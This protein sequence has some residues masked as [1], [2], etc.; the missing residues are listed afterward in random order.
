MAVLL[1]VAAG[2]AN[3]QTYETDW[4]LFS[5]GIKMALKGS[6]PG[7]QQSA[8]LLLIKYGEQLDIGDAVSDLI[9]YYHRQKDQTAKRM[10]LLALYRIDRDEAVKLM[11]EQL[12]NQ[13]E[14]VRNE[15]INVYPR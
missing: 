14:M 8:I 15:I 3:A 7:V 9:A 6:N 10:A 5:S 4:D 12:A 2:S 13:V 11:S 1:V